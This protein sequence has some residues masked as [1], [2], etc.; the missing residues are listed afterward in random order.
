MPVPPVP[1]PGCRGEWAAE[2]LGGLAASRAGGERL[3]GR[4]A[5]PPRPGS[6]TRDGGL[7]A[8]EA[9]SRDWGES[10]GRCSAASAAARAWDDSRRRKSGASLS[11]VS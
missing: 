7:V 11:F 6:V 4:P 3:V 5:R 2:L 8:R 1:V 9:A 10:R